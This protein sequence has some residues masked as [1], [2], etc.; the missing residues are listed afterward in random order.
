MKDACRNLPFAIRHLPENYAHLVI[1]AALQIATT[2]MN[3]DAKLVQPN[4]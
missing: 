3:Y 1:L 4:A 2:K